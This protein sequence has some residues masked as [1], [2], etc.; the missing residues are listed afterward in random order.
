MENRKARKLSCNQEAKLLKKLA[1]LTPIANGSSRVVF[2]HPNDKN[3]IVKVA[4]GSNSFRQNKQEIKLWNQL[5][6]DRLARIYEYGRFVIV[7]ERCESCYT[8]DDINSM[9]YPED[10]E[11]VYYYL[12]RFLG[13]TSDNYQI[14]V[15]CDG[16][17]AA[18]DYGFLTEIDS[19]YQCGCAEDFS[20]GKSL[21]RFCNHAAHL[22]QAKL[23]VTQIDRLVMH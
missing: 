22:L 8:E 23:P 19:F 2:M 16:R 12:S 9:D 4:I 18:Y 10:A 13:H 21:Q 5:E 1:H 14:G 11:A 3:K 6:D 17:W 20:Y 15:M 7:M